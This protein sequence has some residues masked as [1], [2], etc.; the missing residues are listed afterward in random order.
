MRRLVESIELHR[1]I[2]LCKAKCFPEMD[3]GYIFLDTIPLQLCKIQPTLISYVFD[4]C[5]CL[6]FF[7]AL[8]RWLYTRR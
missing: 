7:T 5:L 1:P 2:G 4:D 3:M 8:E 6:V